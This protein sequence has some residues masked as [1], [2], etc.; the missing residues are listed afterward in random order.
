MEE[1]RV[2]MTS[3]NDAGGGAALDEKDDIILRLLEQ[4]GRMT[5]AQLAE[6][7]SL[8][9]SATQSRV[10]KLEKRGVIEG[11]RADINYELTG[12]PVSA[13]V[14]VTPTDR[15]G[16]DID[17]VPTILRRIGG[18]VSCDAVSGAT[19]Y[20]IVVRVP[21]VHALEDL[22]NTIQRAILA[23]T[24]TRMVLHHYFGQ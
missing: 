9:I 5:L 10:Q 18:V 12:K 24:V 14:D 2:V 4:D 8:S 17:A 11:Y 7:A 3:N 19:N 16:G 1:R 6:A 21:S 15:Y 22:L 20:M 23:R 13:Y